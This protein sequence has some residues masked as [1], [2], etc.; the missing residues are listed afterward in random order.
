MGTD[1]GPVAAELWWFNAD[2]R[3]AVKHGHPFERAS[4]TKNTVP[5]GVETSG[6]EETCESEWENWRRRVTGRVVAGRGEE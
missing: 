3:L 1:L 4:K 2:L 6:K 5:V